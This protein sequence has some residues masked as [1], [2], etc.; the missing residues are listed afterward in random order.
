MSNQVAT[1]LEVQRYSSV[2]AEVWNKLIDESVNG[3]FLFRRSFMDYHQDRFT[4]NS[5]LIW[6]KGTLVAVFVAAVAKSAPDQSI[7]VAHPG[8]TYGGLVHGYDVKYYEFE[9]IFNAVLEKI[10]QDGFSKLVL[11]PVSRVFC[12][13]YSEA[14][15]FYYYKKQFCLLSRDVNSVIDLSEP[16]RLTR[17]R[18]KNLKKAAAAGLEI[19]QNDD[20]TDFWSIMTASL[21][22]THNVSPV[23]TI[24][25][26]QALHAANSENIRLYTASVNGRIVGG[27]VLFLDDKRGFIHSQYT[28]ANE[29]GRAIRA[30][31]SLVL[32]AAQLAREK[33]L[34]RF[35]FGISTVK[36]EVNYGLLSQKED[37]G[38]LIE[39]TDIYEKV[40]G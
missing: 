25:E 10:A 7:L 2:E 8:L 11:K 27:T 9:A 30:I 36:S 24:A 4:D 35:S 14:Q 38:S 3:T 6:E 21:L 12:K 33:G 19:H 39:L 13:T 40:L 5:Y 23:H 15:D 17:A 29:E 34:L 28:H 20:F 31:D 18:K 37:F 26:M 16:L 22:K 1:S 32:H